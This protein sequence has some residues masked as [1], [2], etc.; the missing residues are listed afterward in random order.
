[1]NNQLDVEGRLRLLRYGLVVVVVVTFMV[2][3][4]APY[5]ATREL[6]TTIGQFVG[7]AV[8]FT[9]IVAAVSVGVY[10]GYSSLLKRNTESG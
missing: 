9:V 5:V 10:F 2:S 6:G 1:M 8:M 3:L 7:N 4:L